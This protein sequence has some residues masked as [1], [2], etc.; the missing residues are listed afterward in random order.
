[1]NRLAKLIDRLDRREL[2]LIQK[3]L[4]EGNLEMLVKRRLQ[5]MEA[6]RESVCPV[7]GTTVPAKAGLL[8]QFGPKDLRQQARFDAVDCMNYFI[9]EKLR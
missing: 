7:C 3:D 8:I 9:K 6:G 4:E 1:M 2:K 5:A